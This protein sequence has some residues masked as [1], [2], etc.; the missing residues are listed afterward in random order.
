MEGGRKG[1]RQRGKRLETTL[2]DMIAVAAICVATNT[3]RQQLRP[4]VGKLKTTP[5]K[6]GGCSMS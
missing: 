6:S 2:R 4:P 5:I 1:G 3:C